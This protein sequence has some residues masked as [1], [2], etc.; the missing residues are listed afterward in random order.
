K[1]VGA[2]PHRGNANR[3]TPIQGKAKKT[4]SSKSQH[5]KQIA[6]S[7]RAAKHV[8]EDQHRSYTETSAAKAK[9]PPH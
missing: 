3:P 7:R 2:A 9:K 6:K 1:K 8:K 5:R 4:R